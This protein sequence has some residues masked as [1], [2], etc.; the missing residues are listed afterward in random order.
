MMQGSLDVFSFNLMPD[1]VKYSLY[2]TKHH[3]MRGCRRLEVLLHA[4]L[5]L[6]LDRAK[7]SA[8]YLGWFTSGEIAVSAF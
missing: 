4:F 5:T 1:K 3:F 2:V 7:W 6:V 8:S